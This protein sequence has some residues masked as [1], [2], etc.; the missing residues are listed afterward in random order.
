MKKEAMHSAI[1]LCKVCFMWSKDVVIF[2]DRCEI[3]V[4]TCAIVSPTG[5]GC[6]RNLHFRDLCSRRLKERKGYTR[7]RETMGE[8]ER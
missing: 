1:H 6:Y 3:Q 4:R 7:A 8:G 5:I 2:L